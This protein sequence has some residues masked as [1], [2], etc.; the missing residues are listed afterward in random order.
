M[1]GSRPQHAASPFPTAD[2]YG[3]FE[4][5]GAPWREQA[6]MARESRHRTERLL[7]EHPIGP[8]M[9]CLAQL[10]APA[11]RQQERQGAGDM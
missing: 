11:P 4:R 5:E 2:L 1:L 8:L 7:A 10:Q 9:H 6:G 3:N